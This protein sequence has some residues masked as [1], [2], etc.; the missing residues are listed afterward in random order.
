MAEL[1]DEILMAYADGVLDADT[2]KRVEMAL[3]DHPE[4]R[5]RIEKFRATRHPV[6]RAF[7]DVMKEPMSQRAVAIVRGGRVGAFATRFG[8]LGRGALR[9]LKRRGVR[10][11]NEIAIAI[12]TRVLR[13]GR[14]RA[15]GNALDRTNASASR[16]QP[17][18][19][20]RRLRNDPVDNTDYA[21][22]TK[23]SARTV[24]YD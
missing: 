2:A 1:S 4:Y 3:T 13:Y 12:A 19:R 24:R 7:D 8:D 5:E 9:A 16:R 18:D 6:Q 10:R 14:K 15:D 11:L 22:R 23:R 21:A 17:H 20:Q